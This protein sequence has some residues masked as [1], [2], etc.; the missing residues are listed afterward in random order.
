VTAKEALRDYIDGLSEDEASWLWQEL[1]WDEEDG[2]DPPPLTPAQI[3]SIERG[4]AQADAGRLIPHE[5]I[6]LEFG[7]SD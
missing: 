2:A 7:L 5:E 1:R 4:L 3:A 6:M